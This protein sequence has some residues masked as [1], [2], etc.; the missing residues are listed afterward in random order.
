MLLDVGKRN[1]PH[2]TVERII[3]LNRPRLRACYA[4]G[5]RRNPSLAG[6][7]ALHVVID[8][9]GTGA[10]VTIDPSSTLD[11][12]AVRSC[13]IDAFARLSFPQPEG[14]VVGVD[15]PMIFTP[16]P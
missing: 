16:E 7:V 10:S 14:G 3:H 9:A 5:A 4:A 13:L 11:D 15:Y 1:L 6:R 12:A 8:R 2:E